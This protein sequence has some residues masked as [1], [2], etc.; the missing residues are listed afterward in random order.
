[1][2]TVRA[3]TLQIVRDNL[4]VVCFVLVDGRLVRG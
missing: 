3:A 1:M 2:M 4:N